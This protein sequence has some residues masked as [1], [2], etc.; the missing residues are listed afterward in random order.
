MPIQYFQRVSEQDM[1]SFKCHR[2]QSYARRSSSDSN[3]EVGHSILDVK[4]RAFVDVF[5]RENDFCFIP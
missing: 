2:F 4:N 5:S 1:V 3:P